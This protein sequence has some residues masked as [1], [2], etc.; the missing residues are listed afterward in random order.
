MCINKGL[1]H[2]NRFDGIGL[3]QLRLGRLFV[4]SISPHIVHLFRLGTIGIDFQKGLEQV[5][6]V[7]IVF[8]VIS[9]IGIFI[10]DV[11]ELGLSPV[12]RQD[13]FIELLGI[14]VFLLG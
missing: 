1:H 12:V 7:R 6:R 10:I 4:I 2:S 13:I 11:L 3:I 8:L 14:V 5:L 9:A